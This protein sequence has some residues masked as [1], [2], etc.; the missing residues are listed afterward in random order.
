MIVPSQFKFTK[1]VL[2]KVATPMSFEYPNKNLSLAEKMVD[3][4]DKNDG[5]GLA[6]PQIG[7]S[8]RLFVM[9]INYV[10]YYCFNPEITYYSEEMIVGQEGCLSFP[11][12]LITVPRSKQIRGRYLNHRGECI[13]FEL[14]GGLISVCFQHELDHLDGIVMHDRQ[15]R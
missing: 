3:F 6:A 14:N 11:D 4:M 8:K 2:H 1:K 9:K 12:E 5:V 7:I 13:D 15:V 10:T